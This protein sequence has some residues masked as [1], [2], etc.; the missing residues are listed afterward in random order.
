MTA[1]QRQAPGG[2][3]A[4]ATWSNGSDAGLERSA[5][6]S[7]ADWF[8]HASPQQRAAALGLA[9]QQGLLYPHQ[10]PALTNGV[11]PASLPKEIEMQSFLS[12]FLAGKAEALPRF[13]AETI[14]FVDT[15]LD[16]LQQQAVARAI[17]AP[18]VFMLHGLPGTGKSR[19]VT[20]IILQAALRG[21][22][23]LFLAAHTASLDVVLER[24][25]GRSEVFALRF[26]DALEKPEA[27]PAWLRGFT[28]E[29]QRQA[30]LERMLLGARDNSEQ[31]ETTCRQRRD[32]EPLWIELHS[33][34]ERL[35]ESHARLQKLNEEIQRLGETVEREADADGTDSA[36]AAKV[37]EIRRAA[38]LAIH[39]HEAVLQGKQE[40]LTRCDHEAAE[41]AGR[42]AAL[43]PG[44]RAK[45][46]TRF[47]TLAFWLNLFNGQII[48]EMEALLQ[49]QLEMQ[50]RRQALVL[51]IDQIQARRQE[52][53]GQFNKERAALVV[54][55][56][57]ATQQ[58]LVAQQQALQAEERRLDAEWSALSGRLGVGSLDKTNEAVTVAQQAWLRKK[59][60]DEQQCQFAHQWTKF[61]EE[62][63]TQLAARLPSFANLLAGT[64][65]RWHTDLKFREAVGGPLDLVIVEDADTLTESDLLK[66]ARHANR[67]ILVGQALT[68]AA[69]IATAAEKASRSLTPTPS[70]P[71]ACW[72]RLWQELGGDAGVWPYGWRREHGRLVCQLT[73][74]SADDRNYLESEGLADAPDIELRILHR[75]RTRPCLAEVIFAPHGTFEDAFTFM[76]REVQEFPV[77]PLGRTAWWSEDAERVRRNLGP[78]VASI[79]AR[80]EIEPGLRIATVAGEQCNA[81][82]VAQ[83]DFDKATGWDRVK[84]EAWLDR[85]RPMHDPQRTVFLQTPYRFKPSLGAI[86]QAVVRAGDWL[87]ASQ[88]SNN[89][90]AFE[91]VA[92][93]PLARH[94]W[95]REGAGLEF[96]LSASRQADRLPTG[97][98][99][100][101]PPRGFVNYSEA[102]ALI[103]RLESW[104]Q[105]DLNG[106]PCS[107]AVSALY[108]GQ[109]ELLRRLVEQSEILRGRSFPLEIALPSRMQQREYDVFFLS[110]TRSHGHRAVAFGE[111]VRELPLALT[112][113]R[114]RLLV[115]GDP[116]TLS[117]R[118]HWHGPL[119]HLDAFASHQEL[120]RLSRLVA[121]LQA[122]S[123]LLVTSKGAA[124]SGWAAPTTQERG[125]NDRRASE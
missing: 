16:D 84:A 60:S 118:I 120:V 28:M 101:L 11:K 99:Q 22:R 5:A 88:S 124:H 97:L 83:I 13:D 26:L 61:V 108:E 14:S 125:V 77:E 79:A 114:S 29:E 82:R 71:T 6:F 100:G 33:L 73:S 1:R 113:A 40:A 81:T 45:K 20:E 86:V 70:A 76:V 32:E 89:D 64:I 48:S 104:M 122:Q 85:H 12:R 93:P 46:H 23:V 80:I 94:D 117:K 18:D 44:Y 72:P 109:V 98:K 102:Q 24:L 27:I 9:Q 57:Q 87:L 92:V 66:V 107:V 58:T 36:L 95:P 74:L 96:D 116:G 50:T 91:F 63:G 15:H 65:L 3:S 17:G 55:E 54:V 37:T 43:E 121:Y 110:L 68:E 47:W 41:L 31:V 119:D 34:V 42:I 105:K 2:A 106:H 7:W 39:E 62:T 123:A 8:R 4:I 67:C 59:Q 25:V 103:R 52:R 90:K 115:F 78:G 111:D 10:L 53:Q 35:R 75:P 69:S 49:Q 56:I 112:R 30:F 21:Q 19:V 38:E 51:E